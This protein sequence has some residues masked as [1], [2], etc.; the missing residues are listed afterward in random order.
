MSERDEELEFNLQQLKVEENIRKAKSYRVRPPRLH[1]YNC[2]EKMGSKGQF[3]DVDCR[4]DFESRLQA[5]YRN[6]GY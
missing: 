5:Q 4:E 2:E 1:C 6:K 3:C